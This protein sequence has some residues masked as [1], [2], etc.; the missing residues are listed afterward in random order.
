MDS[1]LSKPFK[2]EHLQAILIEGS[3]SLS[4]PR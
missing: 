2:P 4:V 1:F 3:E